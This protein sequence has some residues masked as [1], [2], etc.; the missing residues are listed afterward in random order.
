MTGTAAPGSL[1]ARIKELHVAPGTVACVWLGQAGYIFKSPEDVVVVVDPYLSDYAEQQWGVK[2]VIPAPIDPDLLRPDMLLASHWHEDHLDAPIVKQWAR[3]DPGL[4]LGPPLCTVRAI[5]WGWPDDRVV[6]LS[7]GE[8]Y[9]HLD[10]EI[11]A[12]FARHETPTVPAPDAVGFLLAIGGVRIWDVA[13]TEYDARLRPMKDEHIDV[14]LVPINGVGGNLDVNEA[15]FL[16]W[17]V[18]PTIAV[19]MHY[20][21]WH[22]DGFGP[23]AT[24]DP[25]VFAATAQRFGARFETRILQVGDIATFSR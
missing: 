23:G 22:P 14:A 20:N 18:N 7:L 2:R 1:E 17:E 11:T 10:V 3:Q 15:A 13:D 16:M 5:A 9:Q 24:L 4:F 8:S 6:E 25:R 12:T 19:P 21:M